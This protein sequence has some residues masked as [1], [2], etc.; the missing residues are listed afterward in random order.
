MGVVI[1]T[2]VAAHQ[3]GVLFTIDPV[4]SDSTT[5]V[6]NANFGVGESVVSGESEPDTFHVTRNCD[7]S[8]E[9]FSI[10]ERMVG[11]KQVQHLVSGNRI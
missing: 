10:R 1:Q 5:M 11:G 2:M 4:T 7:S 9:L 3:A 8:I 6:V